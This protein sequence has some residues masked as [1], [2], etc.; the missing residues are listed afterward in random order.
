MAVMQYVSNPIKSGLEL[1][2]STAV[3]WMCMHVQL[4]MTQPVPLSLTESLEDYTFSAGQHPACSAF[5]FFGGLSH[6]LT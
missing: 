4:A 6:T 2:D 5:K 1:L 3:V